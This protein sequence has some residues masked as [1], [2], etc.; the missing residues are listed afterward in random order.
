MAHHITALCPGP[1]DADG[2]KGG[3]S[4]GAACRPRHRNNRGHK[5]AADRCSGDQGCGGH[6]GS[7]DRHCGHQEGCGGFV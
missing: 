7:H 2:K 3:S 1:T 6:Q 4:K 5:D